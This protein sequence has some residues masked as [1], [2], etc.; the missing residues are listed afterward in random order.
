MNPI[1]DGDALSGAG[2]GL[3]SLTCCVVA[4]EGSENIVFAKVV[5]S[6]WWQI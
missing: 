1:L 5:I 6:I 2:T 3:G 4:S